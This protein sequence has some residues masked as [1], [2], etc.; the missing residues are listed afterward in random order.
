MFGG[1]GATLNV[2]F[3]GVVNIFGSATIGTFCCCQLFCVIGYFENWY[4]TFP[5]SLLA[6]GLGVAGCQDAACYAY[7][8]CW[9]FLCI[10]GIF[11]QFYSGHVEM[12][13]I[14]KQEAVSH[15]GRLLFKMHQG[16]HTSNLHDHVIS[17]APLRDRLWH[18]RVSDVDRP[19]GQHQRAL[20]E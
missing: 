14:S 13:V 18:Q 16:K 19:R 17:G 4:S 9:V 8:F 11:T 1:V 3:P 2:L 7:L 20:C 12:R 10:A 5:V 6:A 15:S